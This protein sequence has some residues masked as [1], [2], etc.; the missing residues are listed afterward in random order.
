M[1]SADVPSSPEGAVPG[2]SLVA[3]LYSGLSDTLRPS[4]IF[5]NFIRLAPFRDESS[6]QFPLWVLFLSQIAKEFVRI[7]TAIS[8]TMAAAARSLNSSCGW[9]IQ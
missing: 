4:L 6:H 3:G 9:E 7:S 5:S 8:T 2:F 1:P